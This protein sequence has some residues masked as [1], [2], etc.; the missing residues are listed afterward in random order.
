MWEYCQSQQDSC[1]SRRKLHCPDHLVLL[2]LD[3]IRTYVAYR[4]EVRAARIYE[5][6]HLRDIDPRPENS[7]GGHGEEQQ[8]NRCAK[9]SLD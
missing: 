5:Q 8:H 3:C 7:K 6:V 4:W 1:P 2:G 9:N